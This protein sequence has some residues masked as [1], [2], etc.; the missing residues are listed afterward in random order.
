MGGFEDD[1][2][3]EVGVKGFCPAT[4][5]EAPVVTGFKTREVVFGNWG[6]EVIATAAGE[7]EKFSRHDG[8]DGMETGVIRTGAAETI[9]VEACEGRGAAALE[10]GSEDVG[11]HGDFGLRIGKRS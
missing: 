2:R 6:R 5:T 3:G 9:A 10:G 7:L 4:N 8:A 1:R 11:W